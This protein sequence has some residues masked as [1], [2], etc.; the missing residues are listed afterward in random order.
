MSNA[1]KV[2]ELLPCPFCGGNAE[3]DEV[4]CYPECDQCGAVIPDGYGYEGENLGFPTRS[5]AIAAWNTRAAPTPD[6]HSEVGVRAGNLAY[7]LRYAGATLK[8]EI[9]Q[10]MMD[11]A[12]ALTDGAV[13][14]EPVAVTDEVIFNALAAYYANRFHKDHE[15]IL[16][17]FKDD[18]RA[19][20][21]AAL[22]SK[23]E[24]ER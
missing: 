20:L 15:Y 5:E 8:G 21:Y 13:K 12:T 11:A 16:A 4:F 23:P 1:Q 2:S 7:R 10:L 3:C 19:A 14:A 9:G 24:G 22:A 18:M 6:A 17:N